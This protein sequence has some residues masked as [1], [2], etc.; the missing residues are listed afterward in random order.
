MPWFT[1]DNL[2]VISTDF[3]H[4]PSADDAVYLDDETAEAI[5]TKDPE[6]LQR[7]CT[8]ALTSGTENLAT[9]LCG[10]LAVLTLLYMTKPLKEISF[11]KIMYQHSGHSPFGRNNKV[12]G[13]WAIGAYRP[14]ENFSLSKSEE[15]ELLHLARKAITSFVTTGSVTNEEANYSGILNC[16][17]GAFVSIHKKGHLRGC[18]GHLEGTVP[19]WQLIKD[20]S[21]A[22]ASRDRRFE[23]VTIDELS[24]IEIEISVLSPLKKINSPD[25]FELGKHGIYIQKEDRSGTFLP[26]VAHKTNWTK[27]EFLGHCSRDKAGLGWYGWRTADL[28]IFEATVFEE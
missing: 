6:K 10:E 16:K 18:L 2:F 14:S 1:K 23:P 20:M 28:F 15:K 21:V 25:E 9:A 19:L 3:S 17:C 27:E 22:A 11:K 5:L 7:A 4:Y 26:Q 13:Y 12:V 24:E 8:N